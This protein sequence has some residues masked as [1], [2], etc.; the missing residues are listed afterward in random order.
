MRIPIFPVLILGAAALSAASGKQGAAKAAILEEGRAVFEANCA[1]CHGPA[2][3]GDGPAAAA[4][5][6]KP[7]NLAEAAYMKTRPAATLRKVI[8]EGGQSVGLS[9]VMIGWQG[10]LTPAQIDAVLAYVQSLG[11]PAKKKP[12]A[13]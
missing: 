6:P 10:I 7:R 4:L 5:D 12:A 3:Q 1:S 8:S 2:G 9:P 13:K 11:K